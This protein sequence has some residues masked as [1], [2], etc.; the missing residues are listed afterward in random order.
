[1]ADAPTTFYLNWTLPNWI[2]VILMVSLGVV[3]FGL[4]AS[5]LGQITG[6]GSGE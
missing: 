1:M 6:Q 4:V 3:L 2:T 5:G